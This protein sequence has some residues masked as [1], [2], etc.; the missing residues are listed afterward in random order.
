MMIGF[1]LFLAAAII[2]IA[3]F[4]HFS[5]Y[6]KRNISSNGISHL[7]RSA[8]HGEGYVIKLIV[9]P[10]K[11]DFISGAGLKK[12]AAI[13]SWRHGRDKFFHRIINEE[14]CYTVCH[15]FYPGTFTFA[16]LE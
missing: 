10:I 7:P 6:N 12:V 9:K 15:L 5:L 2:I 1:S 8:K 16:R 11:N 13:Y 14:V 3:L 4:L